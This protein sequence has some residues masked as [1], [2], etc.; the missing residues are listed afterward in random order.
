MAA[1]TSTYLKFDGVA[2]QY[3]N[4]QGPPA[5]NATGT[6]VVTLFARLLEWPA[7]TSQIWEVGDTSGADGQDFGMFWYVDEPAKTSGQGRMIT[8]DAACLGVR[9]SVSTGAVVEVAVPLTGDGVPPRLGAIYQIQLC[10]KYNVGDLKTYIAVFVDGVSRYQASLTGTI[11]LSD[12]DQDNV[13]QL[14]GD[15]VQTFAGRDHERA[16]W[17]LHQFMWEVDRALTI[18]ASAIDAPNGVLDPFEG[19]TIA[20]SADANK[21]WAH[22]FNE[23]SGTSLTADSGTGFSMTAVSPSWA[24]STKVDPVVSGNLATWDFLNVKGYPLR[25][26]NNADV[27]IQPIHAPASSRP[28]PTGGELR[29]RLK[30]TTWREMGELRIGTNEEWYP[31][32]PVMLGDQTGQVI[33]GIE[34]ILTNSS[35]NLGARGDIQSHG[36]ATAQ[37]DGYWYIGWFYDSGGTGANTRGLLTWFSP[38]VAEVQVGVRVG[39]SSTHYVTIT[40]QGGEIVSSVA[41]VT[42]WHEFAMFWEEGTGVNSDTV[43]FYIDGVQ[44]RQE[45]GVGA[46]ATASYVPGV[47]H[48]YN[49]DTAAEKFYLDYLRANTQFAN[50]PAEFQ[51]IVA[52]SGSIV[53]PV[54]QP[55]FGVS[56]FT[57]VTITEVTAGVNSQEVGTT[58]YTFRHSTNGGSSWG[59][60]TTLNDAN[61]LA[62][63]TAGNGQDVLELTA[64]LQSGMDEMSSPATRTISI[65]AA[66]KARLVDHHR[67]QMLAHAG[68][69]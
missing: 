57:D 30:P 24:D 31:T 64:E 13:I 29:L 25:L 45:V 8:D 50:T 17:E 9:Y 53:L 47:Q 52:A 15:P 46:V 14:G 61:L 5:T 7:V 39:G 62:L 33:L 69:F 51:G 11:A 63:V 36:G 16:I 27:T 28:D 20:G 21:S 32:N 6:L 54:W 41:R 18:T 1:K 26:S 58:S 56:K 40:D 59:S 67:R 23:G 38:T 43:R 48:R 12:L 34:S 68:A 66:P 49:S 37:G 2:N 4:A 22:H 65:T 55:A 19:L 60:P 10:M 44:V 3:V 42:G 35:T